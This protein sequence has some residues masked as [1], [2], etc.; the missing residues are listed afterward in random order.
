MKAGDL[1]R[2]RWGKVGIFMGFRVFDGV[3]ECAEVMWVDKPA[4]NGE[5]VSTIQK[6]LIEVIN[7]SR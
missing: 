3:Y 2:D 1:V 4:S 5:K 6:D 7:E